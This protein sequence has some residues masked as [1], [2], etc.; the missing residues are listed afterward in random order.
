MGDVGGILMTQPDGVLG[1]CSYD[2]YASSDRGVAMNVVFFFDVFLH[3]V[4]ECVPCIQS[5]SLD[6][7][8]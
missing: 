3:L 2:G 4:E 8:V 5:A 6:R 1:A 7:H